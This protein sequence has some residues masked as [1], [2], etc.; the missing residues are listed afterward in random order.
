MKRML[1]MTTDKRGDAVLIEFVFS[2]TTG[3]KKWPF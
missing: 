2:E 3:K 1:L